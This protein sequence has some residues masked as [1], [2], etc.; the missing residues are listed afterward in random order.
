M[1]LAKHHAL[2]LLGPEQKVLSYQ[3]WVGHEN[4]RHYTY[5]FLK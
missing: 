4:S 5:T 2:E 3:K 1:Q